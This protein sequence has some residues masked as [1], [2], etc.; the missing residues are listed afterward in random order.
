MAAHVEVEVAERV[1]HRLEVAHL[2]GHVEDHLGPAHERRH[3]LGV[4]DVGDG[5]GD[6]RAA[7]LDVAGGAAVLGNQRV[8]DLDPGPAGSQGQREVR[9]DEAEP[10]GHEA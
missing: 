10:A 5:R 8:D 4:A 9:A 2:A 3:R 6:G 1:R 7:T